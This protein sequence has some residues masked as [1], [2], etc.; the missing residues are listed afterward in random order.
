MTKTPTEEAVESIK[1]L[2]ALS[3]GA[4]ARA[5]DRGPYAQ[6][7][8]DLRLILSE[9]SRLQAER[10]RAVELCAEA[11]DQ[12]RFYAESHAAKGTPDGDAKAATNLEWAERMEA[13]ITTQEETKP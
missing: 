3:P 5:I 8:S 1:G 4:F 13:A 11:A 7:R 12:F 2:T 6:L 10:D 9:L